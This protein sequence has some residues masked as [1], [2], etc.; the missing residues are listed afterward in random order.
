MN[1]GK[2]A[3][4]GSSGLIG[5]ELESQLKANGHD[6]LRL[7]RRKS[8]K[9]ND[10]FWDPT[11]AESS[12]EQLEGLDAIIHLAGE[13][14][15]NGRW[16]KKL[17]KKI[18][19]SRVDGT[20][21]LVE[22]ISR[23]KSPP[24]AFLSASAIG[25]YGAQCG[26]EIIDETGSKGGGFLAD[27]CEAWE[28]ASRSKKLEHTRLVNLRIGVVLDKDGGALGK[29]LLPFKMGVGGTLGSGSQWMSWISLKDVTRAIIYAL[30]SNDISGPINLVSPNP[31]KNKKF[32]KALGKA[33]K[34]PTILP[35]PEFAMKMAFGEMGTETILSDQ[36][37][38]PNQ[39]LQ[40]GFEFEHPKI[41]DAFQSI[42]AR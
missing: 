3:I 38:V 30:E 2:I 1:M 16:T 10:I 36:R 37:I 40:H 26:E 5:K 13:P 42:F 39:L 29:M 27:V 12:D 31:V 4:S 15:A 25:F 34:R 8:D 17:K 28:E 18:L 7:V 41:D 11:G 21:S 19:S 14:I 20:K 32:T 9:P 24:A 22:A 35:A 23:L 6:I 33:L